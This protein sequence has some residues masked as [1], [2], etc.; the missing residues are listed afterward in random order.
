MC[1]RIDMC[2]CVSF[3]TSHTTL[4]KVDMLVYFVIKVFGAGSAGPQFSN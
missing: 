1:M 4:D 2:L 3:A